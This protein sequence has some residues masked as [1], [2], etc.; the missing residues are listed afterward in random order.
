[1]RILLLAFF[2]SGVAWSA[3]EVGPVVSSYEK[4]TGK[5]LSRFRKTKGAS[6]AR[7]N[8]ALHLPVSVLTARRV[9]PL[10]RSKR[11]VVF[12]HDG[13]EYVVS[14]RDP[15]FVQASRKAARSKRG[16]LLVKG[17]VVA[18]AGGAKKKRW[19]VQVKSLQKYGK[20]GRRPRR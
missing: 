17:R 16:G 11:L 7:R 6:E 3:T 9:K 10:G 18:T 15:Y 2:L 19:V 4:L 1:M 13:I 8:I 14:R 20:G 5:R 12:V